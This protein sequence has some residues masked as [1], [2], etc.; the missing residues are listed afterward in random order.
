[1][2]RDNY[3]MRLREYG[4]LSDSLP[5]RGFA[6]N[7]KL[8][9]ALAIMQVLWDVSNR[10]DAD[11][12][13]ELLAVL[14]EQIANLR[15]LKKLERLRAPE[16]ESKGRGDSASLDLQHETEELFVTAWTVYNEATYDHSISLIRDRL[17]ANGFDAEF[18]R[19]KRCF[20]GGC[21]TG[22]FAIAMAQL[23]ASEV[24]GVD[25]GQSSLDFARSQAKRLGAMNVEFVR[26]DATDLSAW[27]T[28]SF[29]VVISN[30]VLHHAEQTER[31][32]T[33]HFR[34]TKPGGVY[35]LYLYG[36]GSL[37][38][39][40]F[41]VLKANLIGVPYAR[42]RDLLFDLGIRQGAV[43]SFLDNVCAPIRKYYLTSE[44]LKLLGR[45]GSF[46]HR[47]L[48]GIAD[49]DDPERMMKARFGPDIWGPEGEVRIAVVK[50]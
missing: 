18:F 45:E 5:N 25:I 41:D 14:D 46:T 2:N 15:S 16:G 50:S 40:T 17:L 7:G 33:E 29:D 8:I 13:P 27:N 9:G 30:G 12:Y 34:I 4:A 20:D 3:F 36:A 48:K 32:V 10:L 35:W 42:V 28:G 31:G 11:P 21:G 49:D 38:W 39:D 22:R 19:G 6:L 1:M 26:H 37:F 24:V 47:N 43:Y 44:I 23:G